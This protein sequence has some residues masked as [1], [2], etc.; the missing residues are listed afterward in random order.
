LAE[1]ETDGLN[2]RLIHHQVEKQVLIDGTF[3]RLLGGTM[4]KTNLSGS[5]TK[6]RGFASMDV[7]RQK[8][9]A[10]KG[11]RAAHE[12]GTAHQ[13]TSEEARAAG[14]KGGMAVSRNREHMSVIGQIGGQ[15]SAGGRRVRQVSGQE[16][17]SRNEQVYA[18]QS[19]FEQH[20]SGSLA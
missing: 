16:D 20:A 8:E 1:T 19:H 9:I 4:A 13:F 15:H 3:F 7:E 10:R 2:L 18:Q 6:E 17:T 11:G 14:K 12:K 5:T